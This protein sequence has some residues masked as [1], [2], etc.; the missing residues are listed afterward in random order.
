VVF[1]SLKPLSY[2]DF[3]K[4]FITLPAPL[5]VIHYFKANC[6]F[7]MVEMPVL[8]VYREVVFFEKLFHVH[9]FIFMPVSLVDSTLQGFDLQL[10]LSVLQFMLNPVRFSFIGLPWIFL[11]FYHLF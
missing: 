7:K 11:F 8:R 10:Y 2:A 5:G 3:A 4:E 6:A 1:I 9:S